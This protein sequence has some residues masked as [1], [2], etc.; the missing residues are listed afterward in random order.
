MESLATQGTELGYEEEGDVEAPF[1][2][3]AA[4]DLLSKAGRVPEALRKRLKGLP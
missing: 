1:D 4:L 2:P 3:Q